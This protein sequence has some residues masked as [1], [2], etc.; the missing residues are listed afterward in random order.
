ME[1]SSSEKIYQSTITCASIILGFSGTLITQIILAKRESDNK[2][3]NDLISFF[4]KITK[5]NKTFSNYI[6]S[7]IYSCMIT[8]VFSLIML[9]SF[10]MSDV[11]KYVAFYFW[12]ISIL[13]FMIY[14]IFI[15]KILITLLFENAEEQSKVYNKPSEDELNNAIENINRNIA[16]NK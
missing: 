7:S 6:I 3:R 1:S 10:A 5:K 14:E 11:V 13:S 8:V 12:V 9:T 15:Y 2:G 16:S 4:F